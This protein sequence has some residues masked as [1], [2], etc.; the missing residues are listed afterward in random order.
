[1]INHID[2]RSLQDLFP[3]LRERGK[4]K[5]RQCQLVLLRQLKIFDYLSKKYE[6]K[7]WLDSG[8]LLGAVRHKGFVP[9]DD[10]IDIGILRTDYEKF[11]RY[12]AHELPPDIFL[13]MP[14]TEPHYHR[15]DVVKLRDKYSNYAG[16]AAQKSDLT[17]HN[18][19]H[20]ELFVY[21]ALYSTIGAKIFNKF[22]TFIK[23]AMG[24]SQ[25][26]SY[27]RFYAWSEES[28][29]PLKHLEFEG[30]LFPCPNDYDGFLRFHYGDYMSLPPISEQVPPYGVPEPFI[31][32]NH[33]E[34]L[35]WNEQSRIEWAKA[36]S[37]Q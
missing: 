3:D 36:Y 22:T 16:L 18:G 24:F 10:D 32:C 23:K 26:K 15:H 35:F 31:P 2:S 21:D 6:F 14:D 30:T 27:W 33:P 5:L 11:L 8:T 28:L 37:K 17:F 13:Q 9:W 25:H 19:L 7:Y 34:I 12:A 1:M 4:N 20:V 29:F